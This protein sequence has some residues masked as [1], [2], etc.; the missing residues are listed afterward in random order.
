M[1][2]TP[3][4]RDSKLILPKW[5][6]KQKLIFNSE[7]NEQLIG[8]ATRGGK[9]F[10]V[11]KAYILWCATIPGL[12]TDI[13]R[14]NYDDV[15]ANHMEGETSFPILLSQWIKDKL[16]KCTVDSIEFWN[17]SRITLKHCADDVV[18]QKHQGIP[19]HVRTWEEATQIAAHR[20]IF[21][22]KWV[23]M[24]EEMLSRVPDEWKGRFPKILYPTNPI[25]ISVPYFKREFV[26][27]G[28]LTI[29]QHGNFK[30]QYIPIL[31]DDNPHEDAEATRARW[32][33]ED[34]KVADAM[35]NANWN[36]LVGEFFPE[37]D[38]KRHVMADFWPPSHWFRFRSF[39]WG[40]AEPFAVYWVAVSDGQVFRDEEGRERW[41]P[42][43]AF[44]FYQEWYGCN[45]K[46]PAEGLRMRNTDIAYG[47]LSRSDKKNCITLTDS[48]PFQDTGGDG[49][50]L[51]FARAG[52][53]LTKADTARVAGWSALRSKLI[54]KH[55]SGID[56]KLP[57]IYFCERCTYAQS[58]IPA[59]PRHKSETKKEDAAEH[60]E[61]THC[62]D[63]IRYASMAH[64]IIKDGALSFEGIIKQEMQETTRTMKHLLNGT[65]INL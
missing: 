23:T 61:A 53:P 45:P 20:I 52:C 55:I 38:Q 2:T 22:N 48:K 21:L 12:Q 25:G 41:F 36:A 13:F 50:D 4:V 34:P 51:E 31:V 15:I 64:T 54:G 60:G 1:T 26:D 28:A 5:N 39:D 44:I 14:L 47:I 43:G 6:P 16:V 56:K 49:P 7:A 32:E 8:G 11:R 10:Y 46:K 63:A 24:S 42:R 37:W 29:H 57:M 62:C 19:S 59:L 58:Y 18:M 27:F 35:L 3:K 40:M 33:T 65:G 17:S 30:R 9:S